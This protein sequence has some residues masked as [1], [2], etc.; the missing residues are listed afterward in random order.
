ML[1][2]QNKILLCYKAKKA[3]YVIFIFFCPL[4]YQDQFRDYM[5]LEAA[6]RDLR[7]IIENKQRLVL[8]HAT[9]GYK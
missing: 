5:F 9:S 4:S 8:A 1:L 2:A 6:R 7:V 3:T